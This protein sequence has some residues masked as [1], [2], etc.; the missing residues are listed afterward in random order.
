[1]QEPKYSHEAYRV[2]RRGRRTNRWRFTAGIAS[3][4]LQRLAPFAEQEG[5]R[6]LI[7]YCRVSTQTQ[8][9]KGNLRE[10]EKEA[11]EKLWAMGYVSAPE[12]SVFKGVESGHIQEDRTILEQAIAEARKRGATIVAV[13]RDRLVR[14]Q[15]FKGGKSKT[16]PPTIGE[17]R[18]LVQFAGDVP[19]ATITDPDSRAARSQQIK[20]GQRAKGR[21][22]G[23][24][25]KVRQPIEGEQRKS[26]DAVLRKMRELPPEQTKRVRAN[27]LRP[28]P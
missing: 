2:D 26:L 13:H 27:T 21:R 15:F 6:P 19:L 18:R 11:L 14:N 10:Q 16:E 25:T 1:M 28:S 17:Y 5:H 3:E 20:R 12:I 7:L 24:P 23:R 4:F 22:G 8:A 9:G